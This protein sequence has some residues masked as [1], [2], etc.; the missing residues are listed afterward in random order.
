ML[1]RDIGSRKKPT[2]RAKRSGSASLTGAELMVELRY[3]GRELKMSGKTVGRIGQ[4]DTCWI[5]VV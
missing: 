2:G 3:W 1:D 5:L 4:K